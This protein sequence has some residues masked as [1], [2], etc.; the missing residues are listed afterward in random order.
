[1]ENKFDLFGSDIFHL[2]EFLTLYQD[3]CGFPDSEIA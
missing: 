3:M 2:S 1:L